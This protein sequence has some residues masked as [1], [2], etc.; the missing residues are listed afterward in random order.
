[1]AVREA[2]MPLGFWQNSAGHLYILPALQQ[3]DVSKLEKVPSEADSMA[4]GMGGQF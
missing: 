1:M 3:K 4:R 2:L